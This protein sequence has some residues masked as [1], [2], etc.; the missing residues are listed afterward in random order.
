[1][2]RP[3]IGSIGPWSSGEVLPTAEVVLAPNPSPMTLDGTNTWVLGEPGTP[4]VIIDPGPADD[5]HLE[6][7]RRVLER[8]DQPV[9]VILLTHGHVDHSE[10][11][12]LFSREL[13]APV[14]ALDPA[15]R[16]GNEGL[17]AGDVVAVG[18]VEIAVVG[19][20]GHS[21]DSL[22][23]HLRPERA[24]LTGDTLL[25]RGT[26]VVAWPDGSL[27]DYLRSLAELRS[28][29]D[30]HDLTHALPGHG[31]ATTDPGSL[32]D[33]YLQHRH[34]RLDQVRAAIE[35]GAASVAEVVAMVYEPLPPGVYPAAYASAAAQWE[36]L[37]GRPAGEPC[38]VAPVRRLDDTSRL[39]VH[40]CGDTSDAAGPVAH[41][42]SHP[43]HQPLGQRRVGGDQQR[44]PGGHPGYRGA[45]DHP[46]YP[47]S[48]VRSIWF[49]CSA[50]SRPD[51]RPSGR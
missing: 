30:T 39:L 12:E 5:R 20:P 3:V 26:T 19:T 40:P 37:T 16:H 23:F 32:L 50:R 21:S 17:A 15:H 44:E 31:P 6:A 8:R 45:A 2:T 41:S 13:R 24:V 38:S 35:A 25:G 1:M 33:E 36:Y 9:A 48:V 34:E 46:R 22:S 10:G 43:H 42:A 11:A 28:L 14:R 47:R 18:S 49:G 29:T 51:G 7:V 4:A 27:R